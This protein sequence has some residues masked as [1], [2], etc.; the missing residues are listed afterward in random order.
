MELARNLDALADVC[1]RHTRRTYKCSKCGEEKFAGHSE[2]CP[3]RVTTMAQ[4]TM[5]QPTVVQP[6]VA[7]PDHTTPYLVYDVPKP[8]QCAGIAASELL[9][10]LPAACRLPPAACCLLTCLPLSR[11]QTLVARCCGTRI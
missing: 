4:P 5:V 7:M 9:P 6:T 2:V 1:N 8:Q 10:L 11:V 3:L